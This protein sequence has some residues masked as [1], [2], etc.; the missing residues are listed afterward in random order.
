MR[1]LILED[2]PA[3]LRVVV[4]LARSLGIEHCEART[5]ASGARLYLEDLLKNNQPLPDAIVLDLDLGYESGY[6]LLRFC[7]GHPQLGVIRVVVWT[8]MG[9]EQREICGL[10]K[11]DAVVSKS[12][13][14]AALGRVLKPL[15]KGASCST[16]GPD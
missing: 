4:D 2:Q 14:A 13:G 5:S 11:V 8:V 1:M 3:D 6:E 16:T 15:A 12:E 10:F 7:H 9:D